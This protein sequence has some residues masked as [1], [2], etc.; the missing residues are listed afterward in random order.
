MSDF[1]VSSRLEAASW[2]LSTDL[3][4]KEVCVKGVEIGVFVGQLV[5]DNRTIRI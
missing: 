2:P 5:T 1:Q 3:I 4:E